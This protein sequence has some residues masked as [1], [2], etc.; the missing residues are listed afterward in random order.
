MS[1]FDLESE[2][3]TTG[4]TRRDMPRAS[5]WCCLSSTRRISLHAKSDIR[6]T[7]RTCASSQADTTRRNVTIL[8]LPRQ[9][10]QF[11]QGREKQRNILLG[12]N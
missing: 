2:T 6:E 11:E 9:E 10:N 8:A 7:T 4:V 5:A 3:S 1:F 12:L